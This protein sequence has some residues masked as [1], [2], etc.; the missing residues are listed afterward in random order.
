MTYNAYTPI[1][2][3]ETMFTQWDCK[4][5]RVDSRI[6]A[7]M[8]GHCGSYALGF[9]WNRDRRILHCYCDMSTKFE[10]NKLKEITELVFAMNEKLWFGHF[11]LILSQRMVTFSV[12]NVIQE[13]S[14]YAEVLEKMIDTV[15]I[16]CDKFVPAFNMVLET[17]IPPEK[18]VE[19]CLMDVEG[20]A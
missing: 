20:E 17:G 6:C 14:A 8:A 15:L 19:A 16:E 13:E 3:L 10:D 11:G 5:K 9:S 1:E 2:M 4:H 12:S 18:A 7:T